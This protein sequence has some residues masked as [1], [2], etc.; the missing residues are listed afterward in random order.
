MELVVINFPDLFIFVKLILL[1]ACYLF[2]DK[3]WIDLM[4]QL[5]LT[6]LSCRLMIDL[7]CL[8][9]RLCGV[10]LLKYYV[11]LWGLMLGK[12]LGCILHGRDLKRH[13]G[14]GGISYNRVDLEGGEHATGS[15]VK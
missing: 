13:G 2:P 3:I 4:S 15:E 9:I 1:A 5:I 6:L 7:V 8:K 11:L 14:L 12:C 10:G